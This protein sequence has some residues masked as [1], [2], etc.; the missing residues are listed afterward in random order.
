MTIQVVSR[1]HLSQITA[2]EAMSSAQVASL[3]VEAS[4]KSACGDF[5]CHV[6]FADACLWLG[7]LL[8]TLFGNMRSGVTRG[9]VTRKK[10]FEMDRA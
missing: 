7:T 6:F 3:A 1:N 4:G 9:G 5:E 10:N 2:E 8:A